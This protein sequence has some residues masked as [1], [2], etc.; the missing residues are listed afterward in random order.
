MYPDL[1]ASLV[2]EGLCPLGWGI[3]S[4]QCF[5]FDESPSLRISDSGLWADTKAEEGCAG[6]H[7]SQ[8]TRAVISAS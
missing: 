3:L 6:Q 5:G 2:V 1:S 4:G 7:W 8:Y